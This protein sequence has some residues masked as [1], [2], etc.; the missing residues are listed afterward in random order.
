MTRLEAIGILVSTVTLVGLFA[1]VFY[2]NLIAKQKVPPRLESAS[3]L[4]MQGDLNRLMVEWRDAREKVMRQRIAETL[5][6]EVFFGGNNHVEVYV[7]PGRMWEPGETFEI[8]GDPRE[9]VYRIAPLTY[10]CEQWPWE[11]EDGELPDFDWPTTPPA[12]RLFDQLNPR[13]WAHA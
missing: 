7:A 12:P 6:D 1:W 2:S 11:L 10:A 3:I 9:I 13:P 8:T 5:G 4:E